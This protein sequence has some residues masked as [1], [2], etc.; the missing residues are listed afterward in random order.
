AS[1]QRVS[2]AQRETERPRLLESLIVEQPAR[3]LFDLIVSRTAV[4]SVQRRRHKDTIL[5]R[6]SRKRHR[7]TA[8]VG[9]PRAVV[10]VLAPRQIAQPARGPVTALRQSR[11]AWEERSR[12]FLQPVAVEPKSALPLADGDIGGEQRVGCAILRRDEAISIAL[13]Q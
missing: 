9:L 4:A 2:E 8:D 7:Q 10:G 1:T 13:T 11:E 3:R 5:M 6:A 12:P